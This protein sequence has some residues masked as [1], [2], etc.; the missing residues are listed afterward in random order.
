MYFSRQMPPQFVPTDL[1]ECVR[2]AL[3]ITEAEAKRNNIDVV[4]EFDD[5]LPKITADPQHIKQVVVNLAAN[6]LQAMEEGGALTVRTI[7]SPNDVYLTFQDTGAGIPQEDLKQIFTPFYS[8]KDI[9]KGTGLGLSVVHGIVK[10]HGGFIQ[11]R[12]KVGEGTLV[13]TAFSHA[14]GET[15]AEE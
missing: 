6:A 1:N 15:T 3:R 9:D 12:S 5:T 7:N 13:E 2:Q 14:N 8:T 11:V 4:C 10:A